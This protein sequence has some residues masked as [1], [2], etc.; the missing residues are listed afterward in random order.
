[1][2]LKKNQNIDL[3][4]KRSLLLAIGLLI[5]TF[6]VSMTFNIRSDYQAEV[7]PDIPHP[8]DELLPVI[9]ITEFKQPVQKIPKKPK[10]TPPVLVIEPIEVPVDEILESIPEP[11]MDID[12]FTYPIEDPI[13]TPP[14]ANFEIFE[15]Q[16]SFPGGTSAWMK[17]LRKNFRYPKMAKR[18]GIEG[19]VFLS[20]YVDKEGLISDINVIRGIGAGCDEEAIRVLKKS[21]KWNPGMQRGRPVKSAMSLSITFR[22][23]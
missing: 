15:D 1:M 11:I 13:E 20:F 4:K 5:S 21:P 2:E 8:F 23:K 12:D 3:S 6:L 9:P 7:F 22:L 17:F 10:L 16:A 18:S 14:K 19:K